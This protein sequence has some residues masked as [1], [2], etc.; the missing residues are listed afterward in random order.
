M[1]LCN[2]FIAVIWITIQSHQSDQTFSRT[3][4]GFI[5]CKYSSI[6][7]LLYTMSCSSG[8]VLCVFH[9]IHDFRNVRKLVTFLFCFI[10]Y[11]CIRLKYNYTQYQRFKLIWNVFVYWF[12][13][14][15]LHHNKI[16]SIK[17]DT[18]NNLTNL[19]GL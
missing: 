4:G 14:R 19:E 15:Y 8:V 9:Y 2:V 13:C 7:F 16:T 1:Y 6:L 17:S 10:Q 12:Y 5:G 3:W 11:T 18:F